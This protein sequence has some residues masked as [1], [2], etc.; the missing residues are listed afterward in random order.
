MDVDVDSAL[1]LHRR[2]AALQYPAVRRTERESGSLFAM[3]V[4]DTTGHVE[5]NSVRLF[6]GSN[7]DSTYAAD[8]W[9][10]GLVS[11]AERWRRRGPS[12]GL[13]PDHLRARRRGASNRGCRPSNTSGCR[14]RE[15]SSGAL[16]ASDQ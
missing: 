2:S 13:P 11:V 8:E 9:M 14:T 10:S 3:F 1:V 12:T 7:E 15:F 16:H 5:K 4:V 6:A